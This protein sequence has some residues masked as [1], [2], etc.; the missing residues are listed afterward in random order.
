MSS[1]VRTPLLFALFVHYNLRRGEDWDLSA[2]HIELK[3]GARRRLGRDIDSILPLLQP[4]QQGW[5]GFA[6]IFLDLG[7][8]E[9]VELEGME[10]AQLG[11]SLADLKTSLLGFERKKPVRLITARDLIRLVGFL[12][13]HA[14]GAEIERRLIGRGGN[15]RYDSAKT[16]EAIIRIANFGRNVPLLRFDDDVIFPRT[17]PAQARRK[18]IDQTRKSILELCEHYHRLA[19]HPDIHYYVF[20]GSYLEPSLAKTFK[21]NS[22]RIDSARK[23]TDLIDAAIN[24]FA[25]RVVTL[26]DLAEL[27][28]VAG[29]DAKDPGYV[30]E[31]K[32]KQWIEPG[33][34]DRRLDLA[35]VGRFLE[36]LWKVGANPYRQVTSGAGLCLSDS[37][38]LDLAPFSNMTYNV[39]WI[40]DHLK[41]SLHHDLRHF[42]V[43]S[44][45][46]RGGAG[47]PQIGRV[48]RA[49]FHQ[50]RHIEGVTLADVRW[51]TRTYL[52]RLLRGIVADSWLR[53]DPR[54]KL[55]A[56]G[57]GPAQWKKI[58][59]QARLTR[60]FI[61]TLRLKKRVLAPDLRE[62]AVRRLRQVVDL[63]SDQSYSGTYL[64][65]VTVGKQA[66]GAAVFDRWK[67][68]GFL[69]RFFPHG[70]A[71]AVE[72]LEAGKRSPLDPLI[73]HLARDFLD[74]VELVRFWKTFVQ[75]TRFLLN[76]RRD[77]V[78]W[79]F[80]V[81]R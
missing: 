72:R 43:P 51:H 44:S 38:I 8:K 42:G 24:G 56:A 33:D 64:H 59:R 17:G 5:R 29:I 49:W 1:L 78:F 61:E 73:K 16:I 23:R 39:M 26:T 55:P 74:Y 47:R 22:P 77:E 71:D 18:T 69:P 65:L 12:R 80:P 21:R 54:V 46:S 32:E 14:T 53:E 81:Q 45:V 66:Y 20:S 28:V 58:T 3:Q 67:A 40:D 60:D 7:W 35:K 52:P 70:L 13:Q 15:L 6:F 31:L 10:A 50:R 11:A 75:A 2:G 4:P 19:L 57:F 48:D 41:F 25:T 36:E 76:E 30:A 68:L 37:A 79:P 34:P 62:P 9:L 63:W 27:S